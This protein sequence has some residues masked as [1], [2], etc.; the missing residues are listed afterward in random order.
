MADAG[1]DQAVHDLRSPLGVI[2]G[3]SELLLHRWDRLSDAE[4]REYVEAIVRAADR[5]AAL[6]DELV[7]QP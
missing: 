5:L 1:F 3:R 2:R 7:E 4:R 6:I